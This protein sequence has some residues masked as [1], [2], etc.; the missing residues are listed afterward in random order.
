MEIP[1]IELSIADA[2]SGVKYLERLKDGDTAEAIVETSDGQF[3]YGILSVDWNRC[4]TADQLR[5]IVAELDKLN[6]ERRSP[7]AA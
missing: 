7:L 3:A 6:S 5:I 2:G 1:N 4:L